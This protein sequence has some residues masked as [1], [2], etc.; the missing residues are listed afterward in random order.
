MHRGLKRVNVQDRQGEPA[1]VAPAFRLIVSVSSNICVKPVENP[2]P[3]GQVN[4]MS[5]HISIMLRIAYSELKYPVG[6]DAHV[7]ERMEWSGGYLREDTEVSTV[8]VW[9][10][11]DIGENPRNQALICVIATSENMQCFYTCRLCSANAFPRVSWLVGPAPLDPVQASFTF[12]SSE[13]HQSTSS[14]F[15]SRSLAM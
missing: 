10:D 11:P 1:Q 6:D 4:I 8:I 5:D 7:P 3:A 15:R 9:L 2:Q 14:T 13:I 12:Q